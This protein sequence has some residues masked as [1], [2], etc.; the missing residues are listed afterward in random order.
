MLAPTHPGW[1]GTPRPERLNDVGGLAGAYRELLEQ[2]DLHDVVV[3]GSS[4]GGWVASRLA[5]ADADAGARVGA[6]VLVDAIGPDL[7]GLTRP[8]AARP[9]A[10]G[11]EGQSDRAP[12]PSPADLAAL[13]AYT[14]AGLTEP[15]L[16]TALAGVSVPTLVIWG[17]DDPVVTPAFGRAYAAAFPDARFHLLPGVGHL[18][19]RDAPEAVSAAVDAF[20]AGHVGDRRDE[21][22]GAQRRRGAP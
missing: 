3:V 16:L 12:V 22:S 11:A 5:I 15:G 6:L 7:P 10:G 19:V 17:E 18:P 4:F 1:D 20:T 13:G 2:L 8:A 21:V 14:R 9:R